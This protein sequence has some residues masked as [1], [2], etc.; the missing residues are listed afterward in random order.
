MNE[1]YPDRRRT[2]NLAWPPTCRF[3]RKS[4]AK[5]G[6]PREHFAPWSNTHTRL[7]VNA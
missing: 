5:A 3:T 7:A 4:E 2:D 1:E 6:F